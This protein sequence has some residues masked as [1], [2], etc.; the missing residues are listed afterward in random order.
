M[1]YS[2]S[3]YQKIRALVKVSSK[4]LKLS[5]ALK[6]K[7]FGLV[8]LVSN[9]DKFLFFNYFFLNLDNFWNLNNFWPFNFLDFLVSFILPSATPNLITLLL[10]LFF[11]KFSLLPLFPIKA[12]YQ[13]I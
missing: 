12:V 8:F 7:K 10:P 2:G 3:K 6:V 5:L 4:Q 9:L 1:W 13:I 11:L